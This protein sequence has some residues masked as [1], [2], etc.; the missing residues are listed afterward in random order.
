MRTSL[1]LAAVRMAA[2][3]A[4]EVPGSSGSM[5]RRTL[6]GVTHALGCLAD[7]SSRVAV[8]DNDDGDGPHF[9]SETSL[10]PY[11]ASEES[12][13]LFAQRRLGELLHVGVTH[14]EERLSS[15]HS[16]TAVQD[17]ACRV[18]TVY[19][20]VVFKPPFGNR[21]WSG[22]NQEMKTLAFVL[23]SVLEG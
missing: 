5:K 20:G 21:F 14:I 23:V 19:H 6:G 11:S 7:I 4:A 22:F 10:V 3:R 18:V 9:G 16:E 17:D 2:K 12:P 1:A 8:M 13:A 15:L